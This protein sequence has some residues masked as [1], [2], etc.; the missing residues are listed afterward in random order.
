[1]RRSEALD[2]A[3]LLKERRVFVLLGAGG[4]GKTSC[5]IGLAVAAARRGLRVGLL[6]IDPAKRLADALGIP[7]GHQ[8]QEISL[9][10]G[11]PLHGSLKAAMLDQKAV[12]DAMVR[13]HAPDAATAAKILDNKLYKAASGKLSGSLEYMALAKLQD[14]VED[15]SYDVIILDTPPDTHAPSCRP[16]ALTPWPRWR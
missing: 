5:S 10:P 3:K 11:L 6:S 2:F 9:G 16:R 8:L 1:M 15:P 4:V 7:L 13:R 14:M 12:F